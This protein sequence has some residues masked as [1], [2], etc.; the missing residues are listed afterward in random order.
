MIERKAQLETLKRMLAR[1]PVVA[2]L[3]PR[4]VGKSTLAKAFT[5]G[6]AQR[7]TTHFDLEKTSDLARLEDADFA[8]RSLKGF[9]VLDE[10]QRRPELF[11]TLR[12]LADRPRTPARFLVLGSAA[13]DLLRQSS[14]SLAGRIEY[15]ELSGFTLDEVGVEQLDQ[16]WLRGGFPRSFLART[17]ADSRAWRKAFVRTFLERDVPQFGISIPAPTLER[18][19]AMLAHYH[20]QIWNASEFAR[21]FGVS[22]HTTR[23]YLES[24]QAT[25]MVRTL[26]PFMANI[27]KRQ[28]KSPKIYLRDSGILHSFLDIHTLRDLERHPKLG[29]SWEGFLIE[30]VIQRLRADSSQ[31]YFWAT[32]TGAE[33]D[34]VITHGRRRYGFEIKRSSAPKVTASIRSAIDDLGLSRVDVIHAGHESYPLAPKVRA[35]AARSLL[36]EIQPLRP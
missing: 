9:V 22:H 19:W 1:N 14:E 34:L 36:E 28:V 3:G 24:L 35:V 18:F 12:V 17:N 27:K 10:I 2:I 4:Q 6:H 16:L 25:F 13:P 31:C 23:H 15:H 11:P 8:L 32:H 30:A 26:R 33:L 21:S 20:G 7:S 29:A 5:D